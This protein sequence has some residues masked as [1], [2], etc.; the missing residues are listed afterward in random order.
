MHS[1]PSESE[2]IKTALRLVLAQ[3][4][5]LHAR[6]A[7][8]LHGPIQTLL[9]LAL[10]RV[11]R[12]QEILESDPA[13]AEA[14]LE[15]AKTILQ[16][17]RHQHV[18]KLSHL[19][20]PSIIRVGLMP[21]ARS[22]IHQFQKAGVEVALQVDAEC[23]R[24]DDPANNQ[25]PEPVRLALYRILQEALT[26]SWQHGRATAVAVQLHVE[27]RWLCMTAQDNGRGFPSEST[28]PGLGLTMIA[29]RVTQLQGTWAVESAP[30]RGTKLVVRLPIRSAAGIPG[31]AAG[32]PAGGAA[33]P[34][35]SH[36]MNASG[37]KGEPAPPSGNESESNTYL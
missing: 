1:S 37:F 33:E 8:Q 24:M 28:V 26:N 12:A 30:G 14:E 19:L 31:P 29:T 2:T 13:Q 3:H 27:G 7:E 4:E 32:N 21:A 34:L 25:I 16:D 5:E 15:Q 20:H 9:V 36:L 18:R 17:L 10:Y 23:E 22:L 6:L 11:N 35:L